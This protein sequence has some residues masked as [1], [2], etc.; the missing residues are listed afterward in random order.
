M[1]V[2]TRTMGLLAVLAIPA[3]M[4]TGDWTPAAVLWVGVVLLLAL[5]VAQ[6]MIEMRDWEN[7]RP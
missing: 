5:D 7:N 2:Q 4:L 3:G 6:M 1:S